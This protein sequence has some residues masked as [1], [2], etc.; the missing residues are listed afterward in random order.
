MRDIW[1]DWV[2]PSPKDPKMVPIFPIP[3]LTPTSP[4]PHHQQ[5][6]K[7]SVFVCMVCHQSGADHHPALKRDRRTD[8]KPEPPTIYA[9]PLDPKAKPTR[10]QKRA[11][12]YAAKAA[13]QAQP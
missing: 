6:R 11:A 7:G 13:E 4:C 12:M 8:P 3:A 1:A 5:I 2:A 10:K 9:P